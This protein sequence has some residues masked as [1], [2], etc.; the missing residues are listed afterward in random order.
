VVLQKCRWRREKQDLFQ[1]NQMT[2][3]IQSDK[4]IQLSL[5]FQSKKIKKITTIP[6][7][8]REIHNKL[9]K[10]NLSMRDLC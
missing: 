9:I 2:Y 3:S 7:L 10:G 6:K 5:N 1:V 8:F 4:N